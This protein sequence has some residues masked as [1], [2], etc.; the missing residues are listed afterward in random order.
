MSSILGILRYNLAKISSHKKCSSLSKIFD[1]SLYLL[2]TEIT[3]TNIVGLLT[4][5]S[6]AERPYAM[7][8]D[9]MAPLP[10]ILADL[11]I[12][13]A[14]S[15]MKAKG[16]NFAQVLDRGRFLGVLDRIDLENQIE[17]DLRRAGKTRVR[18][19]REMVHEEINKMAIGY[20]EIDLTGN[21]TWINQT[22]Q[23][24]LNCPWSQLRNK[25]FETILPPLGKPEVFESALIQ[26]GR[27]VYPLRLAPI[28]LGG[29]VKEVLLTIK[30]ILGLD[31]TPQSYQLL[32]WPF[33]LEQ[34]TPY[35]KLLLTNEINLGGTLKNVIRRTENVLGP[36]K[37]LITYPAKDIFIK[38]Y[39][40]DQLEDLLYL[41]FWVCFGAL[42]RHCLAQEDSAHCELSKTQNYLSIKVSWLRV[43]GTQVRL[44][45]PFERQQTLRLKK[46][47]QGLGA[48]FRGDSS[49]NILSRKLV[50]HYNKIDN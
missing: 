22:G 12:R 31:G 13:S 6:A 45:E 19:A 10:E 30:S 27:P 21:F 40:P 9:V 29:K 5:V 14:L 48:N 3:D 46:L 18:E 17:L 38:G 35:K 33:P 44:Q 42:K 15:E 20:A 26:P 11:P 25:A 41:F 7:A 36:A 50:F 37:L 34:A 23:Q 43:P 4:R 28:K 49:K 39:E 32:F 16:W 2:V 8:A 47:A 1:K 24:I